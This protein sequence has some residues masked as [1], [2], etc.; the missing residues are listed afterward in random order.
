[1]DRRNSKCKSPRQGRAWHH[2]TKRPVWVK[3]SRGDQGRNI[4][5]RC[6]GRPR[7]LRS[8]DLLEKAVAS[9]NLNLKSGLIATELASG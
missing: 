5:G 7:K 8:L 2:K 6:S 4:W 1:M 3:Q 9:G